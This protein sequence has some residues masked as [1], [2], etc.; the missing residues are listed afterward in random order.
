M[1][2]SCPGVGVAMPMAII[3]AGVTPT[4]SPA[5]VMPA[6]VAPDGVAPPAGVCP[7]G[8]SSHR[9]FLLLEAPAGVAAEGVVPEEGVCGPPGVMPSS[10]PRSV[11][12]V[13]S[14][15]LACPG[16]SEMSARGVS[17]HLK[18]INRV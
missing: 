12:G 5:G 16:V 11:L 9:D 8:V 10:P 14:Q 1:E 2:A 18:I 7:D 13:S 15:P 6:G 17:S 4:P 3:P